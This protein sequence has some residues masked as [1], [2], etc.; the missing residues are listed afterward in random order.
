MALILGWQNLGDTGTVTAGGEAAGFPATNVQHPQVSR[1]WHS[2]GFGSAGQNLIWD[3]GTSQTC[4]VMA[5]M[6]LNLS[7]SATI[8]I[9]S[10]DLSSS[11]TA[12]LEVD[13]GTVSAGVVSGYG[14]IFKTFTP[15]ASRYWRVDLTDATMTAT[16]VHVG[17]VFLG[18]YWQPTYGHSYG[19]SVGWMDPSAPFK[20]RGGQTYVD[21]R[22]Q[23]RILSFSLDWNSAAQMFDN[24]FALAKANGRVTDVLAIPDTTGTYAV[25]QMVWGLLAESTPIRNEIVNVYRQKFTLEERL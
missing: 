2:S 7:S 13:T 23:F 11:V 8:R 12:N 18:P 5:L 22:T 10:S 14:N 19:W 17:R 3:L 9:R 25:Q 1:K 15:T 24:A 20:S 6:G 21:A 16:Q 4:G